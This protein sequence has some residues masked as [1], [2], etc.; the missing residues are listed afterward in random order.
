MRVPE[1]WVL[2]LT[3]IYKNILKDRNGKKV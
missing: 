2:Y 3:P 1:E